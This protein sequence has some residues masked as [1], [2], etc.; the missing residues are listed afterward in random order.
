[1]FRVQVSD[2]VA[3]SGSLDL[4]FGE[5][6]FHFSIDS[7]GTLSLFFGSVSITASINLQTPSKWHLVKASIHGT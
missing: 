3:S 1:M 5:D 4:K 2:V 7:A 6:G